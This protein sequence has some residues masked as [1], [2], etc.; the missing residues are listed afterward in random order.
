MSKQSM[1]PKALGSLALILKLANG[2]LTRQRWVN[3]VDTALPVGPRWS[4]GSF[5][6][7]KRSSWRQELIYQGPDAQFWEGNAKNAK[8]KKNNNQ[9][10]R[11][12]ILGYIHKFPFIRPM[13]APYVI[14]FVNSI[15]GS[16]S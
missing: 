5:I 6:A 11:G 1:R 13:A 3:G 16:Q 8:N 14:C 15:E 10:L 2:S 12:E 4:R 9:K 7:P